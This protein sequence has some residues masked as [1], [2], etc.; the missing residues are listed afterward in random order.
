MKF[1]LDENESP[2]VLAPLRTV[3]FRHEFTS[4]HDEGLRGT[5]DPDLIREVKDRG[6]DAIMT[7]DRNQL[8]NRD[9][10]A[11]YIETGLHWIGHRE[12]DAA[13]LQLIAATASAYLAAMPHILDA[14]S[15]VTGA[16]S[17]RVVN[18]PQQAGQR[19]RINPLSL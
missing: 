9:E 10:R 11:A 7:Q 5:L 4:A 17:F 13:G 12:P 14:L 18:F 2:A 6:F 1:F 3:F 15:Q 16:H 19:V 8:S